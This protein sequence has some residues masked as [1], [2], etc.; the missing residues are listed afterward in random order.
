MCTCLCGYVCGYAFLYM[1]HKKFQYHPITPFFI[2]FNTELYFKSSRALDAFQLIIMSMIFSA[3]ILVNDDWLSTTLRIRSTVLPCDQLSLNVLIGDPSGIKI[4][5][6]NCKKLFIRIIWRIEELFS[7]HPESILCVPL[8]CC[9]KLEH[10][11][12]FCLFISL[13]ICAL[14]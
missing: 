13:F 9:V 3:E 4:R 7:L 2:W 14:E 6:N 12:I 1:R 8:Y 5:A 10:F 11:G